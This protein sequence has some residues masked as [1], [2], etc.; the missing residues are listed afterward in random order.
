MIE[1]IPRGK[2]KEDFEKALSKFRKLINSDGIVKEVTERRYFIK[3]SEKRKAKKKKA[4]YN[5]Q[6]ERQ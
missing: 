2:S 5:Q 1:V 6:N 4:K 3:P